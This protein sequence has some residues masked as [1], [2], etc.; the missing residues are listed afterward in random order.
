MYT[1]RNAI[2]NC[3]ILPIVSCRPLALKFSV[4]AMLG[5]EFAIFGGIQQVQYFSL[6]TT[7]SVALLMPIVFVPK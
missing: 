1:S 2:L 6:R 4:R 3:R 5:K 7:F